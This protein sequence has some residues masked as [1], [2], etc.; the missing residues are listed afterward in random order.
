MLSNDKIAAIYE[1]RE[2]VERESAENVKRVR[3][4]PM[5]SREEWFAPAAQSLN[6]ISDYCEIKTIWHPAG[7]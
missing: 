2:A 6:D 7:I 1:L 3:L 5:R 4:Y